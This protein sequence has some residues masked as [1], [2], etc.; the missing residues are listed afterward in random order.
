M[1]TKTIKKVAMIILHHHKDQA[2][3]NRIQ[4]L[5]D[6]S[7]IRKTIEM[8]EMKYLLVI[9]NMIVNLN[10]LKVLIKRD[11][12]Q[13]EEEAEEKIEEEAEEKVEDKIEQK[14]EEKVEQKIEEEKYDKI[15]EKMYDKIGEKIYLVYYINLIKS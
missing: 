12:E 13:I 2:L 6:S 11:Q 8:M 15:G 14:I 1:N 10:I 5:T 4:I 3:I 9:A 7:K